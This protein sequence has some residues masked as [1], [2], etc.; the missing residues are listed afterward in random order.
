VL[1]YAILSKHPEHFKNF[2]G[3]TLEE[4]NTLNNT[5]NQKYPT[6]EQNAFKEQTANEP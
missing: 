4:F 6:Y 1:N 2:T 5:I 3:L